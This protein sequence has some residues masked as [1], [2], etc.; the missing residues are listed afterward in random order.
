MIRQRTD[1]PITTLPSAVQRAAFGLFV[2][3]T[4]ALAAPPGAKAEPVF[5]VR[6]MLHPY[7]AAKGELPP[8]QLAKLEALAG[9]KLTLVGTTRTGA[10]EFA[11]PA[12]RE[13]TELA[14]MLKR[15]REDRSVLWA[16]APL[17]RAVIEKSAKKSGAPVASAKLMVRLKDGV[18]PDWPTLAPRFSQLI[19]VAVAPDRQVGNVWVLRLVAAQSS[20]MLIQL[21]ALL[22]DDPAVQ[23]ADPVLR[24]YA[25]AFPNDP[26]YPLQWGLNDPLAGVNA[27]DAWRL[28]TGSPGV[29][30][31]IVDTGI[32]PH[33]DLNGRVL[34]GYDFIS[35]ANRARDGDGRDPNPRDEGDW[36][37]PGACGDV[38]AQDSFFHGLFVTGII[39]AASNNEIGMT[40]MDWSANLLPVRTLGECGGT[41]D[42]VFSGMMWAAGVPIAGVPPNT[43]PAKVINMSLGGFGPC[44]QSIQEA[45]DEALAQGSV[46]VVSAG[47]ESAD[48]TSFSPANCSGVITVSAHNRKG[49]RAFYSNF[50]RRVDLSA[51]GGDGLTTDDATLSL[52]NDGVTIPGAS[53]YGYALGTSFSAP[54]VSGT[55]S[56]MLARNAL[57]TPG[58]V[59]GI[60][61]GTTRAFPLGTTCSAGAIC[62]S[63]MLDAGLALASTVPGNLAPPPGAVAVIEYYD[64]VLDHYFMT[65]VQAEIDFIDTYLRG[66]FQR[67]GYLFYAYLDPLLAPP[68]A[69]P[70]CRF[71]AGAEVLINSHYFTANA[72][73]C[74]F[75][76]A[77]WPGIW[78]LEDPATFYIQVP[79]AT[80][81]CPDN[82]VP[83]YRF[84]NNRR[85]AN[86]RYTVDLSVRRGMINRAWVPEGNG[87]NAAV[88]CSPV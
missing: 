4:L 78:I 80:G 20:D 88:F 36:I 13:A 84:F 38:P 29:T 41:D 19:G 58:H 34:P 45:V 24:K 81:A 63:G 33:P 39:G 31:A 32:L 3:L 7:A 50:G 87:P 15:I 51:P 23:Y 44:A 55:V 62:G 52:S 28:Q 69:L 2:G 35:D 9:L 16:E 61:Q 21:A 48:I 65:G 83:V 64:P 11:L 66:A 22:Q 46:V 42:D 74:Q 60:L 37:E 56:L 57:L 71:Y 67:T 75:V 72:V 27:A 6:L 86:H 8:A 14:P 40:G 68:S 43:N 59:L 26:L 70:V 30:V 25:R 12:P 76:Q 5:T 85:D 82:T 54:Y 73:D 79:D 49:E 77:R 17:A 47:N 1:N 10:L 53:G 18:A